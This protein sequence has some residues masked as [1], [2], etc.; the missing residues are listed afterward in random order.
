[1]KGIDR[2]QRNRFTSL[3]RNREKKYVDTGKQLNER[4]CRYERML[5]QGHKSALAPC[6]ITQESRSIELKKK[7]VEMLKSGKKIT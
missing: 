3:D 6:K 5:S 7:I 4:Q 1:M 2:I